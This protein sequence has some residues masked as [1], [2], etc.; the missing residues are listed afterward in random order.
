MTLVHRDDWLELHQ[1]DCREVL[2][3]LE[4]ESVNCVVTSP[5]Y[6]GLRDYGIA[7][8]VW[9]GD[10]EHDHEWATE[11]VPARTGGLGKSTLGTA[12]GGHAISDEGRVRSQLRQRVTSESRRGFCECGAWLG[13][14]GLEPTPALFVE[15]VVEVF[16][17]ICRVLRK[18]GLAWLNLGDS[19]AD[20]A[21]RRSDGESYRRD[22]ADVVPGKRN[23]LGGEWRL[24]AKDRMGI[25]HRVVFAL[26]DDGWW[27][28]DEVI[29]Q[30]PNPMP[31]SV[32]D[33]TTP[34]HEL[35]F[36]LTKRARYW[37][38]F[39][40]IREPGRPD[41][42]RTVDR[43]GSASTN[44]AAV[45]PGASRHRG[46]H[47]VKAN[48]TAPAG[49]NKR[50]VWTI[51]TEPYSDAHFATFPKALVEPMILAGC[52]AGGLVLDPFG[53]SG[54]V[55]IVAEALGR[56]AVLIEASEE[57]VRQSLKRIA[58]ERYERAG[59]EVDMPIEPPSDSLWTEPVEVVS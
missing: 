57:Y 32:G 1:G 45:P 16:R 29:W 59:H 21:N 53:G 22:R 30:K 19:Y 41:H 11:V 48:G 12:S 24:K 33:R 44:A 25:P 8:S 2:R 31:S 35:V 15:H 40:A 9:G 47:R 7:P 4:A 20:R 18:D 34:A 27:W 49:R 37:S 36:L 50:S 38:D 26:Q 23:T 51:A 10:P 6:F 3:T 43:A 5:P 17:E 52:P 46:L 42:P 56:H 39:E 13:A 55:G 58:G 28:R 14:L 54:T